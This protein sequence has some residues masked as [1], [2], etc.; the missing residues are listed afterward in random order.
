MRHGKGTRR[1]IDIILS[2]AQ[3]VSRPIIFSIVII[4]IVFLPIFTLQEVEGKMFSPMAFTISFALFGSLIVAIIVSPVLCTYLLKGGNER[5]FF[6]LTKL[7]DLY[8][9]LLVWAMKKRILVVVGSFLAFLASISL[10]PFL[11]TEFIPTLEE[12]SIFIGVNMAPSISL[13]KATETIMKMERRIKQFPAVKEVMSRIG[14]P[15]AGS[16]PHPVNY[17]EIYIELNP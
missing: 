8:R 6:L 4:I 17:A 1:T 5:E 3:E 10:L 14:R 9:P 11:G 16:H 15:E 7:K 13:E 2:A 12:G